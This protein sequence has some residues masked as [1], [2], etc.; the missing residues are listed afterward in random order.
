MHVLF[1]PIFNFK[2]L[3]PYYKNYM[4]FVDLL[5]GHSKLDEDADIAIA[6]GVHMSIRY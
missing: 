3:V 5:T 6:H 2:I 1:P 4:F